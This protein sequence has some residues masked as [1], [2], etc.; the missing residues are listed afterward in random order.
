LIF[1]QCDQRLRREIVS[2]DLRLLFRREFSNGEVFG[3]L[4]QN[5][6]VHQRSQRQRGKRRAGVRGKRIA[7]VDGQTSALIFQQNVGEL[8]LAQR[9]E[10]AIRGK[11]GWR[12]FKPFDHVTEGRVDDVQK[13][14]DQRE[15]GDSRG[16][17]EK[18]PPDVPA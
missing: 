9:I 3:S 2:Q 5:I 1:N 12:D 18:P 14:R 4:R 17:A 6:P 8:F 15:D 16:Q 7:D 11:R 10:I 13:Q